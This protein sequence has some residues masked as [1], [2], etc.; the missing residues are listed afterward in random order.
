[1]PDIETPGLIVGD[2]MNWLLTSLAAMVAVPSVEYWFRLLA[3]KARCELPGA[4]V[5]FRGLLYARLDRLSCRV[6]QQDLANRSY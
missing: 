5:L 4:G 2:S 6:R 3:C 1:M